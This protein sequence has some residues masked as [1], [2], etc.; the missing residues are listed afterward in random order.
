[1]IENDKT[2]TSCGAARSSDDPVRMLHI[3]LLPFLE[4]YAFL[5]AG[6][7]ILCTWKD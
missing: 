1:M 6:R 7:S 4:Q 2:E 5:D 3:R